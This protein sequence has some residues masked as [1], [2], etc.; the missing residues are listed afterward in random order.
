MCVSFTMQEELDN[1]QHSI[2]G[3]HTKPCRKLENSDYQ[4]HTTSNRRKYF[5]S[6][7]NPVAVTAYVIQFL[8]GLV[9]DRGSE[10]WSYNNLHQVRFLAWHLLRRRM[11]S[12]S[13]FLFMFMVWH[14]SPGQ[15]GLTAS[16]MFHLL[17]YFF[18]I[19]MTLGVIS[20]SAHDLTMISTGFD[21]TWR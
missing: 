6:W 11:A 10:R 13:F 8:Q 2:Q 9:S 1:W 4:T 15:V 17:S 20:P 18:R 16:I 5:V 21:R 7:K 19:D 3:L 12:F 14:P